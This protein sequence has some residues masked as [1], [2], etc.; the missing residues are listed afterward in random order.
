M[1]GKATVNRYACVSL[2]LFNANFKPTSV[3]TVTTFLFRYI[4]Q[5]AIET[6]DSYQGRQVDVVIFSCVRAG[7]TRGLGFVNDIR[8]LNVAITR[9]RRAL[10]I[11][12][13]VA[14]LRIN[15]EWNALIQ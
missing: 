6:I 13:S 8:R 10:W 2:A 11:L 14:T 7:S 5:I 3:C 1:S 4:L 9:A 15:P 12:G